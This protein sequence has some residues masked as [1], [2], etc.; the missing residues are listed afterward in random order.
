MIIFR[1][2]EVA[3]YSNSCSATYKLLQVHLSRHILSV[4]ISAGG[5][6]I[7]VIRNNFVEYS[8]TSYHLPPSTLRGLWAPVIWQF[9]CTTC[10]PYFI[11]LWSNTA[12]MSQDLWVLGCCSMQCWSP[13]HQVKPTQVQDHLWNIQW[14]RA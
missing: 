14:P 4:H 2:I 9:E 6:N 12:A 3:L 8:C 11:P 5:E 13:F 10:M 1:I 7:I